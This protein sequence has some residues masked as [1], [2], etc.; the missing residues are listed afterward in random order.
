MLFAY[1][2]TRP[3]EGSFA[4]E[5]QG[6]SPLELPWAQYKKNI[7]RWFIW[8]ANYYNNYQ[9]GAG[10]HDLLARTDDDAAGGASVGCTAELLWKRVK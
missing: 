5:D 2:G 7:D 10:L 4:T 9:G 8:D 3:G 1:A 6:T